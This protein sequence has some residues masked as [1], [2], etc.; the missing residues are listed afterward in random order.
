[1]PMP[2]QTSAPPCRLRWSIV[3]FFSTAV[4]AL[5]ATSCAGFWLCQDYKDPDVLLPRFSRGIASGAHAF[6]RSIRFR[7]A[8]ILVPVANIALAAKGISP[9]PRLADDRFG[10]V[11]HRRWRFGPPRERPSPLAEK[12]ITAA[13]T[14]AV[15]SL[16]APLSSR[17]T[18]LRWFAVMW[19]ALLSF[20]I[21]WKK[22]T[23]AG[24]HRPSI[25]GL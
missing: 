14:D 24:N 9:A 3:S 15:D 16:A 12:L 25:R 1:M 7:S 23:F 19:A 8:L 22:P 21:T 13:E 6:V 20:N 10:V 17:A 5:D 2:G 11:D 4:L 18:F